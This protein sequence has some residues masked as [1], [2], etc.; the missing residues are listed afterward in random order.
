MITIRRVA[1]SGPGPAT[2]TPPTLPPALVKPVPQVVA[3][4]LRRGGA[5]P[6]APGT[7]PV[8]PTP[9]AEVEVTKPKRGRPSKAAAA[10]SVAVATPT[11]VTPGIP[12]LNFT[13]SVRGR[14][15][16]TP[17]AA[18]AAAIVVHPAADALL[19]GLEMVAEMAEAAA[20]PVTD[21]VDTAVAPI[22]KRRGRAAAIPV[23]G[24]AAAKAASPVAAPSPVR[25]VAA[26]PAKGRISYCGD[27]PQYMKILLYGQP[28]VGK[29]HQ[30]CLC[31]T[32]LL[33]V[34]E[35]HI[36]DATIR[37]VQS[38]LGVQIPK[39]PLDPAGSIVEQLR[40]LVEYLQF[41]KHPYQ[42]LCIDGGTAL[43]DEI[44]RRVVA[45]GVAEGAGPNRRAMR[46][47]V[48]PEQG[49]W[50]EMQLIV[51]EFVSA[52]RDLPMHVVFVCWEF[53]DEGSIKTKPL[54]AQKGFADKVPGYFNAIAHL[55]SAVSSPVE[56][57]ALVHHHI[58][59]ISPTV[60]LMGKNPGFPPVVALAH[61][62]GGPNLGTIIESYA[63]GDLY[64]A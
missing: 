31:P 37:P 1:V 16:P 40:E 27:S 63:R 24:E 56:G 62:V 38:Q 54:G 22:K 50:Y 8:A 34:P 49:D 39:W 4:V 60:D 7:R 44:L 55:S 46:D 32:P 64:D 51:R 25:L 15:V 12:L 5:A 58:L 53:C 52:L 3:A 11:T 36:S 18:A 33:F 10:E 13:G 2:I 42:T 30:C 20:P 17:A 59:H 26:A 48:R 43:Q 29:T 28:G 61:G 21:Q 35:E 23:L 6:A 14:L 19:A 41:E 9:A 45:V 47:P 57:G